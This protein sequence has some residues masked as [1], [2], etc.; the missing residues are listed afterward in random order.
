MRDS[1]SLSFPAEN[2]DGEREE[3]EKEQRGRGGGGEKRGVGRRGRE[4]V[5]AA[6][7]KEREQ[8]LTDS[9]DIRV[10]QARI[11]QPVVPLFRVDPVVLVAPD[12]GPQ[13]PGHICG[14]GQVLASN[15]HAERVRNLVGLEALD[16]R[17]DSGDFGGEGLFGRIGRR[18]R[19]WYCKKGAAREE[20]R[21]EEGEDSRRHCNGLT[22]AAI[23]CGK[24]TDVIALPLPMCFYRFFPLPQ[25]PPAHLTNGGTDEAAVPLRCGF[26][27]R[28][29]LL[30][31]SKL[32][33]GCRP[34]HR[35]PPR[36]TSPARKGRSAADPSTAAAR[37]SAGAEQIA[38]S[39][40]ANLSRNH[41]MQ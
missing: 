31:R 29:R 14:L 25:P 16:E 30:P 6:N 41:R 2:E 40:T 8:F 15:G 36:G 24:G 37:G 5:T 35:E 28:R 7:C 33:C 12:V 1:S 13:G 21:E 10:R 11:C 38:P 26:P 20:R 32:R 3:E 4:E 17:C 27:P 9:D 23:G 34:L 18:V 19:A 22:A 39:S